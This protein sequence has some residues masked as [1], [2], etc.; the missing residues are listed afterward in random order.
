MNRSLAAP[1]ETARDVVIDCDLAVDAAR[2]AVDRDV[3]E[4]RAAVRTRD[5][6]TKHLQ[7]LID[8]AE[9]TAERDP[10]PEANTFERER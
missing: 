1:I 8:L 10:D 4:L 7:H 6:A 2:Q 3:D 5:Q 9:G